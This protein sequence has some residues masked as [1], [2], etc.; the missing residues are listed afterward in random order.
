MY[1]S[2][3]DWRDYLWQ[4]WNEVQYNALRQRE[5]QN[6]SDRFRPFVAFDIIQTYVRLHIDSGSD[7]K[8]HGENGM[9]SVMWMLCIGETYA[10]VS[11]YF[12]SE[13]HVSEPLLRWVTLW[14]KE[15]F[16]SSF[17]AD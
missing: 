5:A 17:E 12:I 1:V 15:T 2:I 13:G 9:Y 10:S 7:K 6:D 14:L 8:I 3:D 16:R 4:L 11:I